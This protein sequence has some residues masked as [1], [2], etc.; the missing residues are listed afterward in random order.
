MRIL[1]LS[2]LYAPYAYGGAERVVERLAEAAVAAGHES[3]VAYVAPSRTDVVMRNGVEVHALRHRN[4]L[5]IETSAKYPAPVRQINKLCT[6]FN[7]LTTHD[8]GRVIDTFQPDV[9]HSHSMVELSP[10][11]WREVK[12]RKK[13]LVHTLHDYDL[14]CLRGALFKDGH[15]C[16]PRHRSCVAVSRFKRWFHGSIDHVVGISQAVL[17]KHLE[18]GLFNHLDA[19]SRSVIWN[20]ANPAQ[21]Q[22]RA[23]AEKAP[24]V[25]T[26]GFL[27]RLVEEKGIQTIIDAARLLAPG[28]W[29][30]EIA[31]GSARWHQDITAQFGNLPIKYVGYVDAPRFLSGLDVL[32]VP[33]LWHEPFGLAVI[34]GYLSGIPVLGARIGG[35]EELISAFDPAWLFESGNSAALAAKMREIIKG[36]L[37]LHVPLEKIATIAERVKI[38]TVSAQYLKV[39]GYIA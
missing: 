5:W 29:K 15:V 1:H 7:L 21:F 19:D 38:D 17:D 14:L 31:G 37:P 25:V 33:S 20:P 32:I 39:Y 11:M 12:Q 24:D 10:M 27:G 3:A 16:E 36:A 28:G 30:I 4:P 2:S 23:P 18:E 34:E 6:V 13:R 8:L 9:V 35:L 22:P 26:F